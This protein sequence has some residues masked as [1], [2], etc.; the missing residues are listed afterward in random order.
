MLHSRK[1]GLA[2]AL[3]MATALAA[4]PAAS[5]TLTFVTWQK[6]DPAYGPWWEEVI[7]KFQG[8]R[9]GVTVEMTKVARD[10]FA[11]TM[12]TMF[13]GGTPPDIVH[14]AAFEYQPFADEGFL[15]SLDPYI[16]EA[17]RSLEGWA[18]QDVCVWEEETYCIN[19]LYTGY[20]LAYNE[21]LLKE[22]GIEEVP[23]DWESYIAAAKAATRD[24]N[25][26]GQPDVYGVGMI[27]AAG[28]NLMHEML[29][30]VLDA[31]GSWTEDG[32]PAFDSPAV[33]EGLRRWKQIYT[34]RLTP[35][36]LDGGSVRQLLVEG[37]VAMQ[38]DGPWI[39][40]IL[41]T[42][43]PEIQPNLKLAKSPFEPPVGG[44][45]NVLAIPSD[46][47]DDRKALVWD[48]IATATSKEMQKR[49][50]AIS[51]S[52]APMPG[53]DYSAQA[54]ADP[55]FQLFVE[56]NEAAASAGVD[57][58]PKG[59]ELEFNEVAKIVFR[60][61]QRM[62]VEDLPPEDAAKNIQAEVIE[63]AS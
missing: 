39:A 40:P 56:A 47:D 25:G 46:I 59:L 62:I 49:F 6:D 51:G 8:A 12:Y 61:A 63:I 27:S 4:W 36:D 9:E 18:G 26:D 44:T 24:T 31:G 45:S 29:N 30:F 38:M 35:R 14:L 41:K 23:T 19:L 21:K 48:F 60:E 7:A 17:G 37:R 28:T 22:A 52:P 50:A 43:A 3:A 1:T 34:E 57:R 20:M 15:D 33:V 55:N 11:D 32:E 54:A 10:D 42:A 5:Q 13:A 16:E 53:L 2:V 58:L